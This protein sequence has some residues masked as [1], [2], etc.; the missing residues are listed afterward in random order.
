[1]ENASS[2]VLFSEFIGIH[3]GGEEYMQISWILIDI[4]NIT[5][6][7]NSAVFLLREHKQNE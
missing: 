3:F 4:I 5:T 7:A 1:M 6:V 2:T